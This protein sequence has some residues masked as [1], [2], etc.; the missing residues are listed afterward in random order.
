MT[1]DAFTE[2]R[3]RVALGARPFRFFQTIGSTQDEARAWAQ[4]G[5]DL[6]APDQP[7]AVVIAEEQTA[8]RGRQGRAWMAPPG[9]SLMVSMILRPQVDPERLPQVVMAGA[10]AVHETLAPLVGSTLALKW[11]NDLLVDGRKL[12]GILAEATWLGDELAAVVLGIGLN[13]HTRFEG[14]LAATATSLDSARGAFTDRLALLP[15]LL[16]EVDRW[17]D[18]IGTPD[19]VQAWEA[20]LGTLGKRVT[21]YPQLD[22]R[23]PYQGIAERVDEFGALYVRLASGEVRRVLAADVGLWEAE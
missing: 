1:D 16:A 15:A 21:V 14:D 2:D 17:T 3:L 5:V 7:H 9:S 12:C 18:L 20:R 4:S 8:G 10:V 11:P 6:P 23:D 22:R 13:V 19:L